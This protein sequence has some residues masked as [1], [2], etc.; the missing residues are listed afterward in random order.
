MAKRRDDWE[1]KMVG[2]TP[3]DVVDVYH[4]VCIGC[5]KPSVKR[6]WGGIC[7][8]EQ[9]D[10]GVVSGL[11]GSDA[12]DVCG[13]EVIFV[14]SPCEIKVH[15]ES[16]D[17]VCDQTGE[18]EERGQTCGGED[19][20]ARRDDICA[21]AQKQPLCRCELDFVLCGDAG[22]SAENGWSRIIQCL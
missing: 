5:W 3:G 9:S 12:R 16:D 22:D 1:P 14:V 15:E 10:C 2:A 18:I 8:C 13:E 17:D 21:K 11:D 6:C 19:V 4:T 20:G 7:I